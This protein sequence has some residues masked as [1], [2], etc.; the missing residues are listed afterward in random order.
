MDAIL[1]L[2]REFLHKMTGSD[3]DPEEREAYRDSLAAF[4]ESED[5]RPTPGLLIRSFNRLGDEEYA[6]FPQETML[7]FLDWIASQENEELAASLDRAVFRRIWAA[8]D[9][10][11]VRLRVIEVALQWE[12]ERI[13]P[14][15]SVLL[16]I[17]EIAGDNRDL[18]L[19]ALR[20][21]GSEYA[22]A[23]MRVIGL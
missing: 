3:V 9:D 4:S 11:P 18:V 1:F 10:P 15:E 13:S 23:V 22:R 20:F 6:A 21:D 17:Y 7:W 12:A 16:A 5:G 19:D 14:G 8:F 2:G